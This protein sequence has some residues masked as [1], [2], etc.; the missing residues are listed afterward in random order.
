M[1]ALIYVVVLVL[2]PGCVAADDQVAPRSAA[3]RAEFA[4]EAPC[5]STGAR[6]GACPG[7][8]VDHITALCAGGADAVHNMQWQSV[9]AAVVKDAT[10]RRVCAAK[11]AALKT[12]R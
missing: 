10:E 7:F 3:V 4:R 8:I 6:R 2:L 12:A 1:H 5:P 11:K 9:D